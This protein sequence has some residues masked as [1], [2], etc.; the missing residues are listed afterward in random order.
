MTRAHI[1]LRKVLVSNGGTHWGK[2]Y[3]SLVKMNV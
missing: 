3:E 1:I 2:K